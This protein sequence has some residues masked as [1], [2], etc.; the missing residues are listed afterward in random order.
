MANQDSFGRRALFT[1]APKLLSSPTFT[2]FM[3]PFLP[4][5]IVFFCS[6]NLRKWRNQ[7]LIERYQVNVQRMGKLCYDIHLQLDA[8]KADT[9][10]AI[11]DF[12]Q[13]SIGFLAK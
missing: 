12:I 8:K 2:S 13:R 5:L 7:G 3:D 10:R 9:H 6:F 1:I 11:V 4:R